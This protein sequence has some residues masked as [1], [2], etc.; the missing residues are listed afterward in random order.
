MGYVYVDAVFYNFSDYAEYIQGRRKLGEVRR[1][2]S[3]ALV[4]TGAT[5]PALPEEAVDSLG[6]SFIGELE[7]EVY[8]GIRKLKLTYA[9]IQIE[10]RTALSYVL[11]RPKG[12]SPLIGVVALEQMGYRVDPT[13]GRLIKGL[14]LMV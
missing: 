2:E 6:L 14:P 1:L 10:D 11:V 8:E 4:N 5:F 9:L 7:A 12:T 13:T 3:K